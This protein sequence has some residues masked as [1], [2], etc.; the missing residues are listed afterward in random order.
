[1]RFR[2]KLFLLILCLACSFIGLAGAIDEVFVKQQQYNAA[3]EQI[4]QLR[5]QVET[6]NADYQ[7]ALARYEDT[8]KIFMEKQNTYN[9]AKD[10][11][12][13][14]AKNIDL[15]AP[16]KLAELARIYQASDKELKNA[17]E[18]QKQAE[19]EKV[20][21]EKLLTNLQGQ[22]TKLEIEL[23]TI[24]ADIFDLELRQPVWVEG[25]GESKLDDNTTM[26]DCEK[27]ALNSAL[28]NAIEK[29]G[30]VII[31]SVTKVEMFQVTKDEIKLTA[32]VQ[33]L[34]QDTSG[35]YGK[36]IR[37]I[38]GDIIKYQ[39]KVRLK[40]QNVDTY[41]PY[42]E[43]LKGMEGKQP[44]LEV[45][46]SI[47]SIEERKISTVEVPTGPKTLSGND[48]V[49]SVAFSPNGQ[50]IVSGSYDKTVKL[51]GV[52]GK[53]IHTLNGHIFYVH[54]V[55]FSPDGQ[56]IVSGSSD[57]TIRLWNVEGALLPRIMTGHTDWVLSVAISPDGQTIASG[58]ADK[59]INIWGIDGKLLRTLTGHNGS[60][61]TVAFSPK[62]KYL[63][64]GSDDKS[65]R[66]WNVNGRWLDTLKGH[67]KSVESVAF[68]P[69][70]QQIVSG[71][72]DMTIKLWSIDGTLLKTLTGH[73][74]KVRSVAFSPD[75]QQI[76]SGSSD[77]TIK[78][79]SIKGT[80]LKT[81]EGHT[82]AVNSV[83]FSSD[84]QLIVSGSD[85]KTIK[86]WNVY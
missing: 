50:Q 13:R 48:W 7:K 9:K 43:Q 36:A 59:T 79:W 40:V 34:E 49:F 31:D 75:G 54:S 62:G 4:N 58:S 27:L 16:E 2:T 1:M 17:L 80:L 11:Y 51:W 33:V 20:Y 21:R 23:L 8:T 63:V 28:N 76:V 70:G 86:I 41:N 42:R 83:A 78:L 14:A 57:N 68:S 22:K 6:A 15:V 72:C 45:T 25:F 71:S 82:D 30:K 55:A 60:V 73:T 69:D 44:V 53:L 24:K 64:S 65:I 10:D 85:D 37:V 77:K 56:R 52:D 47:P 5:P 18:A 74:D 61:N 66:L 46:S 67:T 81:L 84:G 39:A 32:K 35:D 19:N 38:S 12:E 29:G 26:K 3:L